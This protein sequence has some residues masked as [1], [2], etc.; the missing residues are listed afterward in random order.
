MNVQRAIEQK[1]FEAGNGSQAAPAQRLVDFIKRKTS[2]DLPDTS[3]IPGIFSA[4]L[5]E[6]LPSWI[7][8]RLK[9]GI[10]GLIIR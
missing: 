2:V 10:L 8:D 7:Y 3:Y 9:F 6:L 4:P 5:H 1:M